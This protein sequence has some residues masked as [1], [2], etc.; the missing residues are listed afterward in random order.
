MPHLCER[1]LDGV[2]RF[3][4]SKPVEIFALLRVKPHVAVNL[5]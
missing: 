1:F 4:V 3:S 2:S 5:S